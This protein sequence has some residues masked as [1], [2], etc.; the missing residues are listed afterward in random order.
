[1][2]RWATV[3]S[4]QK[5]GLPYNEY[6]SESLH[7]AIFVIA[8]ILKKKLV[9]AYGCCWLLFCFSWFLVHYLQ[10]SGF[11]RPEANRT[12]RLPSRGSCKL[13]EIAGLPEKAHVESCC[14][15]QDACSNLLAILRLRAT[16][17][18]HKLEPNLIKLE[19]FQG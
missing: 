11:C 19:P 18:T 2:A 4:D 1:M 7:M 17:Q 13:L 12:R 14:P 9:F 15:Q 16:D 3:F 8:I 10:P 5:T 6:L